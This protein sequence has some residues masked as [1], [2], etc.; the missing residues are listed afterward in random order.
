MR[1]VAAKI[2]MRLCRMYLNSD[3]IIR[4]ILFTS[5]PIYESFYLEVVYDSPPV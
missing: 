4:V 1:L 3:T 2:N 5:H